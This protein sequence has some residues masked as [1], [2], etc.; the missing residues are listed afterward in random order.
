MPI[1]RP[2]RL[3]ARIVL[4][5]SARYGCGWTMGSQDTYRAS[6]TDG[7]LVRLARRKRTIFGD[8]Y[9]RYTDSIYWYIRARVKHHEVAED[10][11]AHVFLQTLTYL[12]DIAEPENV[13]SWLYGIARRSIVDYHRRETARTH[14][15]PHFNIENVPDPVDLIEGVE[16]QLFQADM[17]RVLASC[18]QALSEEQQEVMKLY[19]SGG[20]GPEIADVLGCAQ[21]AVRM[22]R[23][24]AIKR[25]RDCFRK[26]T[27][28]DA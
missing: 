23:S 24:R 15:S 4:L 22:R 17:R 26:E 27:Q 20:N 1:L 14:Q 5:D 8:I 19:L 3:P 21:E 2:L 16:D 11:M 12:D 28:A 25:L 13:R 7:E 9:E 18:L 10:L 6:L